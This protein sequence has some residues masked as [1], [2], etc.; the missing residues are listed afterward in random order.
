M[1]TAIVKAKEQSYEPENQIN[2]DYPGDDPGIHRGFVRV[3]PYTV[4]SFTV[5]NNPHLRPD[6]GA[7]QRKGSPAANGSLHGLRKRTRPDIQQ[8]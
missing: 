8:L 2:Y 4:F 7:T 3:Q 6:F 1:N 5:G